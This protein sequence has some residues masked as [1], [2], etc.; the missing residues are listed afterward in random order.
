MQ[1]SLIEAIKIA[2]G[3]IKNEMLLFS[4]IAIAAL[5]LATRYSKEILVVYIV[6]FISWLI[7]NV[8]SIMKVDKDK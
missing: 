1:T 7:V 8:I 6:G 2:L 4:F 3:K 5:I